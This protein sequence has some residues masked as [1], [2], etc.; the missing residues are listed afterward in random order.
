MEVLKSL[1]LLPQLL[2]LDFDSGDE[3]SSSED[4]E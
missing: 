3:G 2:P 4:I 1:Q